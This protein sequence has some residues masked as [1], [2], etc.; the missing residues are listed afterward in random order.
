MYSFN[1]LTDEVRRGLADE[2]SLFVKVVHK[3]GKLKFS[4]FLAS[5]SAFLKVIVEAIAKKPT[6]GYSQELASPYNTIGIGENILVE[7]GRSVG[8]YF[9]VLEEYSIFY[10]RVVV[11]SQDINIRLYYLGEVASR[12]S[13][14][15]LLFSQEKKSGTLKNCINVMKKGVYM[16]EFDNTFSWI[17]GKSIRYENVVYSPLEIKSTR[18][19]AWL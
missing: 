3:L 1:K 12:Q 10:Y 7:R 17:N 2:F 9:E 6:I 15:T 13:S 5:N 16:F 19:D 14:K 11:A 4:D 8:R 18:E